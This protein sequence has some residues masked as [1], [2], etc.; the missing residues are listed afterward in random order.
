MIIL[1]YDRL[2]LTSRLADRDFIQLGVSE[3]RQWWFDEKVSSMELCAPLSILP[4]IT[5]EQTIEIMNS[6]GFD[7][8]PVIDTAGAIQGVATLGSLKSK[9]L[10]GKVQ[11]TDAVSKATYSTFK[12][13]TLDTTLEKLDRIL[14][15]EHF[16]FVVHSQRLCK[17]GLIFFHLFAGV[18]ATFSHF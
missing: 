18:M 17:P 10:K 3:P 4:D 8:L 11:P 5:V 12:K 16:A 15:R 2:L 13:V 7:Q 6:E 1:G 14:D 9:L